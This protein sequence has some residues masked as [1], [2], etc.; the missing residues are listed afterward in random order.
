MAMHNNEM[1]AL[2]TPPP[3]KAFGRTARLRSVSVVGL[4][5]VL[6]GALR[7]GAAT[8]YT[9]VGW[10]NLGMHCVDRDFSVFTILPPY[11]TINAQLIQGRNGTATRLTN[12]YTVT[13]RA[14]ADA[15]GSINT[16]SRG[17]GNFW[18]YVQS[19]FGVSAL[20]DTGLPVPGPGAYAMPGSSNVPQRMGWEADAQ[21]FV[22]YGIPIIP[23]DDSGKPNQYP[24]MQLT[25]SNTVGQAVATNDIVLPVSDEMNCVFCHLSD[26]VPTA[27]PIAGWE[28]DP[29]PGRDYRLNVIRRAYS[30]TSRSAVTI[31]TTVQA[32]TETPPPPQPP[33]M[34]PPA[35]RQA[36]P[37]PSRWSPARARSGWSP[38]RLSVR[39][40]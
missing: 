2:M 17:K 18:D 40:P 23:Y 19:I 14:V 11:N 25:A 32:A 39:W 35:R 9:V 21:W 30:A 7:T 24:L 16:S 20:E 8:N 15:S 1:G 13:Y 33:Q 37:N 10:N 4:S 31:V 6:L 5:L 34:S 28:N 3:G 36:C 27:R 29:N 26:S 38:N 22:A 12:G